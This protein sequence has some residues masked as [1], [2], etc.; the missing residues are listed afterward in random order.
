VEE[1]EEEKVEEQEGEGKEQQEQEKGEEDAEKEEE[2]GWRRRRIHDRALQAGAG[3]I[4][5][6]LPYLPPAS[7]AAALPSTRGLH[8]STFQLN[9]SA[10][11]GIGGAR[12]G[13]VA[14]VKGI[15]G[16]VQGV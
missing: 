16:G 6:T 10:L 12:R 4:C 2:G 8:S 15:V 14:R 5:H 11:Y 13:C 1:Q 9:L 7:A 3:N